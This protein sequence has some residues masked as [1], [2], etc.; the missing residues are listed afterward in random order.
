[1]A[2]KY[3]VPIDLQR[4]EL[5]NARVQNLG[6]APSTPVSGQIYYDTGS[7]TL[8]FYNATTWGPIGVT[9][10]PATTVTAMNSFGLT[11][12]VGTATTYARED[13]RHS[14]PAT[15][16]AANV[17]A[18]ANAGNATSLQTGTAA[19]RPSTGQ[20]AG[21]IYVDSDDF[22]LWIATNATTFTQLAAFGGAGTTVNATA[23][24]AGSATTYARSDHNHSISTATAG[25]S[26]VGDSASAGSGTS[27]ALANHV[28]GREAFGTPV[29]LAYGGSNTAGSATTVAKSDHIHALPAAPT[30]SSVGAVGNAGGVTTAQAGLASSRPTTGQ[31]AGNLYFDTDDFLFYIATGATTFTQMAPFA[32]TGAITTVTIA[33]AAAAGSATT[34]ARGDHTHA[35]GTPA[36]ATTSAVGDS[37]AAGSSGTPARSDHTHGREAFGLTAAMVAETFGASNNAGSATTLARVDHVH[38]MP[39]APTVSSIGA[40]AN[41]GNAASLQ[42]GTAAS[43]PASG[44]TAGNIYVD[45]DDFLAY[46]ATNSTTFAQIAPFGVVGSIVAVSGAAASAGSSATYARID[47]Q[48]SLPAAATATTSAVGDVAA[49]GSSTNVARADHTHGREA[50]GTVTGQTS[51]AASSGNGSATT[52]SRS[53]HTHGTPTHDN[54]AHSAINISA[55]AAPTVDVSWGSHKIT[56]LLDPTSAQDAATKN[57]VDSAVQGLKWKDAVRAAS[58]ANVAVASALVNGL[59]MDGVTLATGDRVILKNQ[60]ATAE[61]GIYVVVASGAASRAVDMDAAAEV[62]GATAYVREG[63]ANGGLAWTITTT[64]AIT[65]GTTGLTWAIQS[66][67]NSVTAGA[68]LTSSGNA[69]AVG[70]GTGITVAADTVAVDTSVVVRKFTT[71]VGNGSLTSITVNHNLGTQYVTVAVFTNSGV[72]DEIECDVQHTDGNNVTLLFSVAPTSNQYAVVIHG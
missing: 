61:N 54:T 20:T 19:G 52:L 12:T 36:A 60:T 69:F 34:Y 15:P 53:D 25:S 7:N 63:T 29:S 10:S 2:K 6:T 57:Y 62:P 42:T 40:V 35:V 58:T 16:T 9:I 45:N 3:L 32:A 4:N 49:A 70:A 27:M 31:V 8:Q 50:F 38:G 64:G 48:H 1:M 14:T 5:Q 37:A 17:G 28:H 22:L 47:H 71:T 68:G 56:N 11:S 66:G 24:A 67:A 46:I 51:F 30:A 18:V 55:L 26:A 44:Q 21:N 33:A 65:L 13:H 41:A 39:A 23:S 72:F 43:R 59:S